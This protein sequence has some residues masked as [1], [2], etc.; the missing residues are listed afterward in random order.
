MRRFI[1]FLTIPLLLSGC[2]STKKEQEK[3][4]QNVVIPEVERNYGEVTHLLIEW[5]E[6]FEVTKNQYFVYYYSVNCSHCNELKNWI[7]EQALNRDDIFFVKG[8][9]KDKL[10]ND[11]TGTIGATNM[12]DIAI[13]GYPS[14]I[15]FKDKKVFKNVAGK[16][17]IIQLLS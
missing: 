12:E 5:D 4:I 13:L 11:V 15:E 9:S 17:K 14:C 6:V 2:N 1:L 7:I 3:D 8:S 16:S 10:R